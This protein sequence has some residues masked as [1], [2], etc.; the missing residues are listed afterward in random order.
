MGRYVDFGQMAL[1][2]VTDAYGKGTEHIDRMRAT[3]KTIAAM[4]RTWSGTHQTYSGY[5]AGMTSAYS[6]ASLLLCA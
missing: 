4:L 1:S 2:G 6:R 3:T 5:L